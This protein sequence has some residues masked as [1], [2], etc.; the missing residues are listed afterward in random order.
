MTS[1]GLRTVVLGT[2]LTGIMTVTSTFAAAQPG[3]GGGGIDIL[4]DGGSG[5]NGVHD[6]GDRWRRCRDTEV[7][8]RRC[9]VHK[10]SARFQLLEDRGTVHSRS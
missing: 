5:A 8:A 7:R 6:F 2:L 1:H 4:G 3:V 9:A 10:P